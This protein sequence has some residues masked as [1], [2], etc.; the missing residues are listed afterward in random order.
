MALT[1]FVSNVN[2]NSINT[3]LVKDFKINMNQLH[4]AKISTLKYTW[5]VRTYKNIKI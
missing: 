2:S 3:Y 4:E 5:P 1:W